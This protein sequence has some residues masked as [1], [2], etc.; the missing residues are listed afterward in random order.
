MKIEKAIENLTIERG[1]A[2]RTGR[3]NLQE[4]MQLGIEALE[5]LGR[6]SR[7]GRLPSA[8]AL[9]SGGTDETIKLKAISMV[10]NKVDRNGNLIT[11][12]AMEKALKNFS[13]CLIG[14]EFNPNVPPVGR[15]TKAVLEDG[16]VKIEAELDDQFDEMLAI[17]PSFTIMHM[18]GDVRVVDDVKL[19]SFGLTSQPAD[20]GVTMQSIGVEEE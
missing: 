5:S 12:E 10:L 2:I 11:E 1:I 15:V 8:T 13:G 14:Y 9:L 19:I 18:E 7:G 3:H 4:A 20:D 17:V 16:N 6:P